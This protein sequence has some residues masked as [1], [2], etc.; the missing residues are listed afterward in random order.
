M[1]FTDTMDADQIRKDLWWFRGVMWRGTVPSRILHS[2]LYDHP[3]GLMSRPLTT[4]HDPVWSHNKPEQWECPLYGDVSLAS[5]LNLRSHLNMA[6]L[7]AFQEEQ[8]H[9]CPTEGAAAL[10]SITDMSAL[11]FG[12]LHQP[13]PHLATV[14]D[15]QSELLIA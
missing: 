15:P 6:A 7:V 9:P 3:M 12:Q 4:S 1:D 8:L 13:S 5:N 2:S 10:P 11:P 14:Y